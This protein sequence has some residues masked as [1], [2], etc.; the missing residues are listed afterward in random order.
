MIFFSPFN[1]SLPGSFV[2]TS[3]TTLT[4]T[5]PW[6]LNALLLV[7]CMRAI[8]PIFSYLYSSEQWSFTF[9]HLRILLP[10]RFS[11]GSVG[12]GRILRSAFSTMLL[13]P[14]ATFWLPRSYSTY[15]ALHMEYTCYFLIKKITWNMQFTLSN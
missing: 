11:S 4:L 1:I 15:F 13:V 3:L 10:R 7:N 2:Y 8:I 5:L 9:N 14:L 6:W 12:L